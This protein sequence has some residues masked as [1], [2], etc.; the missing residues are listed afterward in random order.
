MKEF[1]VTL[2]LMNTNKK[3]LIVSLMLGYLRTAGRT[4]AN[5]FELNAVFVSTC[6]PGCTGEANERNVSL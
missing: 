1:I 5:T 4:V 3:E 2:S 6:R